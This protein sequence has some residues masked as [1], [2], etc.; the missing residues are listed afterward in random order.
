MFRQ[1]NSLFICITYV[2]KV[3]HIMQAIKVMHVIQVLH[4]M[5]VMQVMKDICVGF[6]SKAKQSY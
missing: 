5:Q 1:P 4:F 6:V 3:M 2:M